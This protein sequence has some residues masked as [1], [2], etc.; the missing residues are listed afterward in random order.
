M[1]FPVACYPKGSRGPSFN[2]LSLAP[3]LWLDASQIVGLADADPVAT[4]ADVSGN[5]RDFTQSTEADKPVYK[6]S[7][8]NGKPVVRFV[9]DNVACASDMSNFITNSAYTLFLVG[10]I[11]TAA[12][13]GAP[14]YN[15]S[16]FIA[17]GTADARFAL[18]GRDDNTAAAGNYDGSSD[19]AAVA[20]AAGTFFT[21]TQQ[22]TGGNIT[23]QANDG[24]TA[25][26][27]SGNTSSLIYFPHLGSNYNLTVMLACDIAEVLIFNSALSAGNIAL[28]KAYLKAKYAH[29]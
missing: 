1:G 14:F 5:G 15:N 20:A 21:F 28:V 8:L 11:T 6:T 4:W 3:T 13:N 24:S 17:D 25:S 27:A 23:L 10:K 26:S 9:N 18:T 16:C 19:E 2:P 29:Y 7:I 22:H 12:N